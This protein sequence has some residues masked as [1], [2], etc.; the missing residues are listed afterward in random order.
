MLSSSALSRSTFRDNQIASRIVKELPSK[1]GRLSR[2][3]LRNYHGTLAASVV[4]GR[5]SWLAIVT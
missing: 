5:D 1:V 4:N 2:V 3:G